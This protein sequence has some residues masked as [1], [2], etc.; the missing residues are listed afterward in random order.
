MC[1]TMVRC[2]YVL[3]GIVTGRTL[4]VFLLWTHPSCCL[5]QDL[6][7]FVHSFRHHGSDVGL[8]LKM[9][10][11]YLKIRVNS[12][13]ED[14]I[15]RSCS[16]GFR[17]IH[18][19]VGRSSDQSDLCWNDSHSFIRLLVECPAHNKRRILQIRSVNGT[20]VSL[21]LSGVECALVFPPFL[22]HVLGKIH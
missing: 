12:A 6:Q 20:F 2:L 1:K 10:Y 22:L 15:A 16:P 8:H 13:P 7:L 19:A 17:S 9:S 18:T 11:Y 14:Q 3:S 4:S 5:V 21:T